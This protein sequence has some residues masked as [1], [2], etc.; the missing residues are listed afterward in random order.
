MKSFWYSL[1][2]INS[3]LLLVSCANGKKTG[4]ESQLGAEGAYYATWT[5][6]TRDAPSGLNLFIPLKGIAG[7]E[8][9][10]V[11]FR[12]Q[13]APLEKVSG[14]ENLYVAEFRKAS[15]SAVNPEL[16]MHKDPR[17][18]YG[19]KVVPIQAQIPFDL[20]EDEAVIIYSGA[21]VPQFFK[22]TGIRQKDMDASPIKNP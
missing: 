2:T 15:V 8:P 3:V 19:N 13:K 9:D 1:L 7:N 21:G 16:I 12:G 10:S 5:S 11:Y 20:E 18:E 14:Q 22:I 17:K 6:D 4:E